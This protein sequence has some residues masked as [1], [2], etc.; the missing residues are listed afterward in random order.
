MHCK[1]RSFVLPPVFSV[2]EFH[3]KLSD[4]FQLVK[5]TRRTTVL[6]ISPR[7]LAESSVSL[8]RRS[9]VTS[10]LVVSFRAQSEESSIQTEPLTAKQ[11]ADLQSSNELA[12]CFGQTIRPQ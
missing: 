6:S 5:L 12:T 1:N 7:S 8:Y 10:R 11:R 4:G 3:K 9:R 2:C